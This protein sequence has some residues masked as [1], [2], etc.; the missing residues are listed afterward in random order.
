VPTGSEGSF[1]DVSFKHVSRNKYEETLFKCEDE[2]YELDMLIEA[3][4]SAVLELEEI[5]LGIERLSGDDK[6]KYTLKESALSAIHKRSIERLY[7]PEFDAEVLKLLAKHPVVAIPNNL[8]RLRQKNDE[9]LRLRIDYRS[10]A[11]APPRGRVGTRCAYPPGG[12][13]AQP[14]HH[15]PDRQQQR[16]GCCRREG[17]A[18]SALRA[19]GLKLTIA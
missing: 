18:P 16:T 19:Q 2:R 9:W 15:A 8:E 7:G 5:Q 14:M 13:P 6:L 1:S 17:R 11:D 3:N 12:L 4:S 10:A